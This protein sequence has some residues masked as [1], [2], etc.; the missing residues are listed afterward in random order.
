LL[1]KTKTIDL[2]ESEALVEAKSPN[3]HSHLPSSGFKI[4]L[5]NTLDEGEDSLVTSSEKSS[6]SSFEIERSH[7]RTVGSRHHKVQTMIR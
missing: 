2:R 3:R 6:S 5:Q 7:R 4:Q 1:K